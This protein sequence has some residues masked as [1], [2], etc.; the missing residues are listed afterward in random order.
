MAYEYKQLQNSKEIKL[1]KAEHH[2]IFPK[3]K[4]DWRE[5][6]RYFISEDIIRVEI[7]AN[8]LTKATALIALPFIAILYVLVCGMSGLKNL[9][10]EYS[11]LMN[12]RKSGEFSSHDAYF[13]RMND[14]QK[15]HL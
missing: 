7:Y 4:L 2:I 9:Q 3:I 10:K 6:C 1:S 14:N 8:H 15:K 5:K 11:G 13:K 12:E